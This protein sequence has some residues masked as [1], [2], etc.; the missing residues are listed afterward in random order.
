M[1]KILVTISLALIMLMSVV[2][3]TT[4]TLG[5]GGIIRMEMQDSVQ[6]EFCMSGLN[7]QQ[8]I[9]VVVGPVCKEDSNGAIGCQ[10]GDLDAAGLLSVIPQDQF[11]ND[12]ECTWI[13]LVTTIPTEELGGQYYF[14]INGNVAGTTIGSETGTVEVPE[15]G[16][17]AAIAVIG[18]AGLFIYKRRE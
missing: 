18:L 10:A 4:T 13:D 6:I 7:G 3:A 17:I 8:N 1:K 12:G 5:D 15:F 2:S 11:I 16:V 14:T 9:E